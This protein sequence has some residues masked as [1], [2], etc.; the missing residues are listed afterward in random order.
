MTWKPRYYDWVV[1]VV[2]MMR[3]GNSCLIGLGT[4]EVAREATKTRRSNTTLLLEKTWRYLFAL[5][6]A[7]AAAGREMR[8]EYWSLLIANG[9]VLQ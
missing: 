6:D 4:I 5:P 1:E 7:T 9:V 2:P 3:V 8:G